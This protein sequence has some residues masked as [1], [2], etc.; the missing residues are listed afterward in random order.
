MTES[1]EETTANS[2]W[3]R[4]LAGNRRFAEG[5]A[6]HPWQ[7]KETVFVGRIE[8]G[9]LRLPDRKPCVLE[10]FG[11]GGHDHVVQALHELFARHRCLSF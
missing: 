9:H 3:S 5:K 7:D 11:V 8:P 6:E 2:T 10:E 4:M 1:T